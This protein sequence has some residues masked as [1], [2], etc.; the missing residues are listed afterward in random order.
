MRSNR[1]IGV[2]LTS[3]LQLILLVLLTPSALAYIVW[4]K[5]SNVSVGT[6]SSVFPFPPNM[7]LQNQLLLNITGKT[8]IF[9]N[10]LYGQWAAFMNA[11]SSVVLFDFVV[12]GLI[13]A[14]AVG[15]PITKGTVINDIAIMGSKRKVLS[16]RALFLTVIAFFVGALSAVLLYFIPQMFGIKPEIRFSAVVLTTTA[17]AFIASSFFVL[18]VTVASRELILP[19]SGVFLLVV[20]SQMNSKLN[21]LLLPFKNLTFVLW[22]PSRFGHPDSYVYLGLILYSLLVILAVRGFE[23]GDFY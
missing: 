10:F 20:L 6:G 9:S 7:T 5:V 13:G 14:F 22:N 16:A 23:G 17:S 3:T 1:F 4:D 19:V 21:H 15:T 12:G 18:L 11:V 8:A 2:D